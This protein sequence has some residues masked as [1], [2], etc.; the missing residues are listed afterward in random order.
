MCL[1]LCLQASPTSDF[2]FL[3][4]SDFHLTTMTPTES[5]VS[6]AVLF[7]LLQIPSCLFEGMGGPVDEGKILGPFLTFLK[8]RSLLSSVPL[9]HSTN[10]TE[11]FAHMNHQMHFGVACYEDRGINT[12]Y[13]INE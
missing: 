3:S 13:F 7:N 2:C 8:A 11:A 9:T 12:L 10:S 1:L 5:R 6:I 4:R